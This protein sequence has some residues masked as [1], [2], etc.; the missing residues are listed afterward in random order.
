[1]PDYKRLKNQQI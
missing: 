1:M